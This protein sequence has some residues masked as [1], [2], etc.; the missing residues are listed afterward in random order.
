M[1]YPSSAG[2]KTLEA[3]MASHTSLGAADSLRECWLTQNGPSFRGAVFK[4]LEQ[5]EAE[6]TR[7]ADS[8]SSFAAARPAP[9]GVSAHNVTVSCKEKDGMVGEKRKLFR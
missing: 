1:Q 2:E 3:R 6:L 7:Q 8:K 4:P 5:N 9:A